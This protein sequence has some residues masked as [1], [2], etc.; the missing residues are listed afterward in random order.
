MKINVETLEIK[1]ARGQDTFK[2]VWKTYNLS[3]LNKIEEWGSTAWNL[4]ARQSIGGHF[5]QEINC[6]TQN[7][8]TARI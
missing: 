5:W 3:S 4:I 6:S 1:L 7:L 8:S 2:I